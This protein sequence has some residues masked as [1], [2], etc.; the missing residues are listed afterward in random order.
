MLSC[1]TMRFTSF[2]GTNVSWRRSTL[3]WL[4]IVPLLRRILARNIGQRTI[5]F[6]EKFAF[7]PA[8]QMEPA[9]PIWRYRPP[10][11]P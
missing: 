3:T 5:Y 7:W 11:S 4:G 8:E 6:S 10:A 2:P 1:S 9:G